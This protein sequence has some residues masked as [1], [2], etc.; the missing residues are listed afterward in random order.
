[1]D[2][3]QDNFNTVNQSPWLVR[4]EITCLKMVTFIYLIV[5]GPSEDM[6]EKD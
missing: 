4:A 5:I 2:E 1:M 6:K 3:T